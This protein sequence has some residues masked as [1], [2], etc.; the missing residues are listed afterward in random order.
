MGLQE[1]R[2]IIVGTRVFCKLQEPVLVSIVLRLYLEGK[3]TGHFFVT[4]KEMT[5]VLKVL[6]KLRCLLCDLSTSI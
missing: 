3:V 4:L 1:F 6:A 2:G 5:Y